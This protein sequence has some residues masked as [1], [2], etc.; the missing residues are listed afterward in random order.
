VANYLVPGTLG[1]SSQSYH[2]YA[3]DGYFLDR[4][5]RSD[6]LLER[7]IRIEDGGFKNYLGSSYAMVT[8]NSNSFLGAINLSLDLPFIGRYI[9]LKPYLDLGIY[10]DATPSGTGTKFLFSGGLQLGED[11]WPV[12]LYLPLFGSADIMN[13]HKARGNVRKRLSLRM[14]L[15]K[16]GLS[17]E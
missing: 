17:D 6:G 10:D 16:I 3:F 5:E 4:S 9:P 11:K 15:A 8:G 12:A 13:I 2:D 1:M 14:L 7:Q